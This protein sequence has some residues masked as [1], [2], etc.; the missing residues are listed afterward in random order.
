MSFLGFGKKKNVPSELPDLISDEIEKESASE[1]NNFLGKKEGSMKNR[2]EQNS[3]SQNTNNRNSEQSSNQTFNAQNLHS[4]N[5]HGGAF[6]S[7]EDIQSEK[8]VLS[9][10]VK[11]VEETPQ[12]EEASRHVIDN[13]FFADIESNISKELNDLN[14]LEKWFDNRFSSRDVL[15]DMKDYWK[16]QKKISVLDAA[17]RSFKE[18]ISAKVSHLQ[19]LEKSW[20]MTYFDLIEKEEEIRDDERELKEMLKEFMKVCKHK[21][22][23]MNSGNGTQKNKNKKKKH[24]NNGGEKK[25][26]KGKGSK[27]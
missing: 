7:R 24:N 12:R 17:S 15:D 22:E 25:E 3:Y 19:H 1:L 20:Q 21:Q 13:S 6:K 26:N 23:R 27:K 11:S 5:N 8:N 16:N 10:L 9:R 14:S 4:S 18:R 2:E